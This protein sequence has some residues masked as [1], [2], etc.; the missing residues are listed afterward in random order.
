MPAYPT[1]KAVVLTRSGVFYDSGRQHALSD[2]MKLDDLGAVLAGAQKAFTAG[3]RGGEGVVVVD[4]PMPTPRN[5]QMDGAMFARRMAERLADWQFTEIKPWTTFANEAAVVH[6]GFM[7]DVA[8]NPGPLLKGASSP[9]DIAERLGRYHML[10]G[11]PW[12][13][14][15][16]VSGCVGVRARYTDPRPG[17]QPLWVSQGPK[18]ITGAGPLIWRGQTPAEGSDGLVVSYDVNAQYL[19]AM[20][21]ARLA[22]GELQN[23]GPCAFDPSWPGYWELS[24]D[25][26]PIVLLDGKL[27][28]PVVRAE[29]A[30]KRGL[31]VSTPVAKYLSDLVGTI[32]VLDSWT[33]SNG[34]TIG[35]TFAERLIAARQGNFGPMGSAELAVKRTY[36]E[37]VG[38]MGRPG[39]SLFRPDW[40]STI[41]DTARVNLL[42]RLDK[43]AA[44]DM[45][46]LR[47]VEVRTDAAFFH[48]DDATVIE[49][50]TDVLGV[51]TGPGTFQKPEVFTVADYR[52]QLRGRK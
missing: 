19:A 44:L 28:P 48:I 4:T 10:T 6:V 30:H 46:G 22:W 31:W 25:D 34:E 50:L 14:T 40:A 42:R 47:L 32:D 5:T 16:G 12:R 17:R 7:P 26:I 37:T 36:A 8:Q 41:M 2:R 24:I 38:M 49:R 33:C 39:G 21:I 18:G 43:V 52:K 51:G 13:Y 20:K 3:I 9:K 27:R 45:S 35:R 23:T 11:V 29:R 1:P 15:A